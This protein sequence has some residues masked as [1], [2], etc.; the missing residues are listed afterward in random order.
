MRNH[1]TAIAVLISCII[2]TGCATSSLQTGPPYKDWKTGEKK[3]DAK[4]VLSDT[5]FFAPSSSD[6]V[7]L[8][9]KPPKF[10]PTELE[11]E[12]LLAESRC[13][14]Q[15]DIAHDSTTGAAAS[16]V[17]PVLNSTALYLGMEKLGK[18]IGRSGDQTTNT[19]NSTSEIEI[20]TEAEIKDYSQNFNY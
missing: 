18:G 5:S 14:V 10:T 3:F 7:M 1:K 19:D 12:Q 15:A 20:E 2:S 11:N 16:F 13:Q 4:I 6:T 17:A 9:C 8:E